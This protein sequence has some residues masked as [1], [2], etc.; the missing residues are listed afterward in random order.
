VVRLEQGLQKLRESAAAWATLRR[1]YRCRIWQWGHSLY[2]CLSAPLKTLWRMGLVGA[3]VAA[4]GGV[5]AEAS[6]GGDDVAGGIGRAGFVI[7]ATNSLL[8]FATLIKCLRL[9]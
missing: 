9:Q 7:E 3:E 2:Q 1:L 5:T 6:E 4:A 8:W